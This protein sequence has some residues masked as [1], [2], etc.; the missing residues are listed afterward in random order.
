MITLDFDG[1]QLV[2]TG[3]YLD[4]D[5]VAKINGARA[6]GANRWTIPLFIPTFIDALLTVK[7]DGGTV[8]EAANTWGRKASV[9]ANQL[10]MIRSTKVAAPVLGEY[11]LKEEQEQDAQFL[12]RLGSG[13][14]LNEMRTGKTLTLLRTIGILDAFPA[15]IVTLPSTTYEIARQ[16]S[17]AYPDKIITVLSKG[18]T[19]PQRLKALRNPAD[20]VIIGHNQINLHSKILSWGGLSA[21]KRNA[22]REAG[23]YE[24]KELNS[25]GFKSV[26]IDEGHAIQN[27]DSAIT[28]GAWA[29]GDSIPHKFVLTGTP[30]SNHDDELWSLFRF[31]WPPL[32]PSRSKFLA[33]WVNMVENFYGYQE[34]R[35][36]NTEGNDGVLRNTAIKPSVRKEWDI[37][38][39]L[40]HVRRQMIDGPTKDYRL[41][42][43]ELPGAQLKAYRQLAEHSMAELGGELLTATDSMSMRHRLAQV[44]AGTPVITGDKVT[45]LTTPSAKLDALEEILEVSEGKSIVVTEGRLLADLVVKELNNSKVETVAILGGMTQEQHKIAEDK[46]NKGSAQVI[47]I[48]AAG[49]FGKELPAAKRTIFLERSFD[50]K[51]SAQAE[52]RNTSMAQEESTVEVIDIVAKGTLDEAIRTAYLK[53]DELLHTRLNDKDWVKGALYGAE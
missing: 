6:S 47:V 49:A 7:A 25:Y 39:S 43:V 21:K 14:I 37:M 35:A 41:I 46:F 24:P 53:K 22:E 11:Q 27:P 8:T 18:M 31:C 2:I 52:A 10:G 26:S 51:F 15:L 36:I 4:R 38:F 13:L 9:E 50:Y 28:R 29:L 19:A 1:T 42:P 12:A 20:I 44:A 34:C 48:N 33:R 3:D 23:K 32:F 5:I 45:A 17:S 40:M 16:A 30:A